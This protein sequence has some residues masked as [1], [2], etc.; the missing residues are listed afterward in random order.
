MTLL[1]RITPNAMLAAHDRYFAPSILLPF[2]DDLA[3][4]LSRLSIGP[5]LEIAA[6]TGVLTQAIASALS[7]GM[8]IVATDPGAEMVAHATGKPGMTR[9]IW[10]QADPHAL[11]FNDASF[12]IV[13]CQFGLATLGDPVGVFK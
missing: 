6:G 7:V 12:G 1:G 5:L 8:T 4:R 2:A 9:V 10:Q 13:A 3:R 11:P